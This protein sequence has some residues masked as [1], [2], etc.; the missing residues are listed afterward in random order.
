VPLASA[1]GQDTEMNRSLHFPASHQ[2]VGYGLHHMDLLD[3][4]GIC[5]QLKK[6]LC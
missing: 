5:E 2:W 3:D 6:W 4:T 1:L